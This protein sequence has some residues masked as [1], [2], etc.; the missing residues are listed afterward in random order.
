MTWMR[1]WAPNAY[2]VDRSAQDLSKRVPI[3][4]HVPDGVKKLKEIHGF[5]AAEVRTPHQ[6]LITVEDILNAA[7]KTVAGDD[8][9]SLKILDLT[10]DDKGKVVV[11]VVVEKPA[12]RENAFDVGMGMIA[13]P[14]GGGFG[15]G[16]IATPEPAPDGAVKAIGEIFSL[17]DEKN[18]AFKLIAAEDQMRDNQTNEY[19]LTFQPPS[20]APKP[21]K[22]VYSGR[23]NTT[24]D[25]PFVLKDVPLP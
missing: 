10:R 19:R 20:G 23:R 2:D 17:V 9:G 13:F 11:R 14:G 12:S 18:Q 22:L 16:G 6:P 21:A 3:R 4:M 7:N 5:V 25:V 24:I 15:M 8:G 1:G